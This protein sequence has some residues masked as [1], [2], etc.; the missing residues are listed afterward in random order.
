MV[1][2]LPQK[3]RI[4]SPVVAGLYYPEYKK[5]MLEL[6]RAFGLEAGYGGC[7]QAIIVPH[8]S[9]GLSGEL[10]ATAFSSATGRSNSVNR[11][12]ILGP[13]HDKRE[14]GVFLSNSHFFH[15]PIGNIR[16]DT[17][18]TEELE[19]AGEYLEINDIPHLGE[20]SIEI[21]LPFVKYCFPYA[22]IVPI[23]MGQPER[24]YIKDLSTALKNVITPVLDETL[25]VV[26]CNLSNNNDK[27]MARNQ[28]QECFDL[29]AGKDAPSLISAILDGRLNPCGGALVASLLESGLVDKKNCHAGDMLSAN[30]M[31]DNTVFYS[32]FSFE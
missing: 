9:W 12:V 32:A 16:V 24:K 28:A 20:H 29:F 3:K 27:T 26:S 7:A 19:F 17:E 15:T 11:V 30:S 21:L 6:I 10:S 14:R 25:L 23:L 4:R 1:A 31:E 13:I 5:E 22:S 2:L 18:T 8:G